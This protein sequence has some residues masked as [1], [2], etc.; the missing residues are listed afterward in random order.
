MSARYYIAEGTVWLLGAILVVS[1]FVG[2]APSQALPLLNVTP[3]NYQNFSR[4]VAVLLFAATVYLF[5]EWKQSSQKAR[6]LFWSRIRAGITAIW[7]VVSIWLSC[8]EITAGT[9]FSGISPAWYIGFFLIGYLLGTYASILIFA[10]LMIRTQT[11]AKTLRLPRIPIATRAQ[12]VFGVPVV[13]IFMVAGYMLWHFSPDAIKLIGPLF[14]SI[15]FLILIVERFVALCLGRDENGNHLPYAK[16]IAKLKEYHNSH[17]YTYFLIDNRDKIIEE[18]GI[19]KKSSPRA[20]QKTLQ[21]KFYVKPSAD[22]LEF[23]TELKEEIQLKGYAKDGNLSNHSPENRGIRIQKDTGNKNILRVRAIA[24]DPKDGFKEMEIPTSLVE[25]YAEEYLAKDKDENELTVRKALSYAI[26]QAVINTMMNN[27]GPLLH[28]VTTAGLEDQVKELL[29]QN[30]DVNER[31]EYGWTALLSASAQGYPRILRL[32]LE[33]GANPDI[34]NVNGITPLMY[35]AQYGNLEI[36]KIL[37]EYGA[38]T[39]LRDTYGMTALIVATLKGHIKVVEKLLKAGADIAIKDKNGMTA[40]DFAYK[41]KQGKIAK[42][43][44]V[45]G[46]K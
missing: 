5:V 18:I 30:V 4:I 8:P 46:N 34:S 19:S 15:S 22:S 14:A 43:L 29:K 1:R 12:Y 32:L 7:A 40:L 25:K 20:I 13:L 10:T 37:L 31:A 44:R 39:D 23:C 21:E 26:N 42:I 16:C 33:A 36:S 24:K 9:H 38:N 17:D 41:N 45:A 2:L 27:G 28:R 3:G 11:E 6:D 35:A